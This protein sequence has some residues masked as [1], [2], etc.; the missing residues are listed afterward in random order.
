MGQ[1]SCNL[2]R[3]T[4]LSMGVLIEISPVLEFMLKK[5]E[6]AVFDAI[7]Y[8]SSSPSLSVAVTLPTDVPVMMKVT[9]AG[10]H[11]T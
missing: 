9:F 6:S 8:M 3:Q 2:H 7:L 5:R 4:S 10:G 1:V 11:H